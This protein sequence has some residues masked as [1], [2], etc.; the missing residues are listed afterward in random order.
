MN[1]PQWFLAGFAALFA[2]VAI[3]SIGRFRGL[4]RNMREHPEK[5]GDEWDPFE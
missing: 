3:M 5:L 2:V 1:A 4:W